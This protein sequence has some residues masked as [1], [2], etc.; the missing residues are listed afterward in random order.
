[1]LSNRTHT[2]LTTMTQEGGT[3]RVITFTSK[4]EDWNQWS[5]TFLA[6]QTAKGLREVLKPKNPSIA[7]SEEDNV[8]VYSNL[9]LACQ[10]DVIFGIVEEAG[11]KNFP[12]GDARMAWKMLS[13]KFEPS[14]GALKD[15]LKL[16]FQQSKLNN[17]TEDPDPWMNRLELMRI[18]LVA[19]KVSM[20]DEDIILHI[21]NNLP[22]EYA[23][24]IKLC[25]EEL[26]TGLSLDKLKVCQIEIQKDTKGTKRGR[27]IGC[28]NDEETI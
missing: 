13:E 24:T 25:E 7:Q 21:L 5:K 2:I 23:T 17:V 1:M 12:D 9:M 10:D 3:I 11:S 27:N 18:R 28:A 22:K 8:K 15:Q 4:D 20:N 6:M 19:L 14:S 16:E 26:T